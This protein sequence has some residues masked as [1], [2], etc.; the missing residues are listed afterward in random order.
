MRLRLTLGFTRATLAGALSCLALIAAGWGLT[1][2]RIAYERRQAVE[3]AVR[4]NANLAFAFE[5]HTIST[6]KGLERTLAVLAREYQRRSLTA[7]TPYLADEGSKLELVAAAGVVNQAGKIVFSREGFAGASVADRDYFA[8]HRSSADRSLRIGKPVKARFT[9]RSVIPVTRR[10][11]LPDGGFGGVAFVAIDPEYFTSFYNHVDLGAGGMVVLLGLDGTVR[12][13]REGLS[14]SAGQDMSRSSLYQQLAT[15]DSGSFLTGGRTDGIQRYMSYRTVRGYPLAVAV[16]TTEEHV[17]AE[18]RT[19]ERNYLAGASLGTVVILL[20]TAGLLRLQRRNAL[21]AEEASR[22]QARYRATFDQSAVGIAHATAE[23]RFLKVNRRLCE[24]LG[25]SEEELLARS[26]QDVTHPEDAHR[27]LALIGESIADP[28][29]PIPTIEKRY[30]RSDGTLLWG[31]AS[32]AAVRDPQGR[33]DYFVTMLEDISPRKQ[34]EEALLESQAQF[35]QLANHIPQAFW[36]MDPRARRMRY[37]SPAMEAISGKKRGP[38]ESAWAAWKAMIH[39]EDR[40]RAL[41]AYRSMPDGRLDVE[42][43]IVGTDGAVRWVHVRGFPVPGSA[44]E[45]YRVAGT[46]EDVTQHKRA[47]DE[48]RESERRFGAMLGNVELISMMLDHGARITYCNDYL[49]R[50]TGWQRDEVLGRNWFELFIPPE[51]LEVK[52]VFSQLLAESP[53][54]LHHENEILTRSGERRMIRWNNS[55]L[56]SAAG[57]VIGTASIGEDITEQQREHADLIKAEARYR[58]TFDE[59][60]IGITHTSLDGRLIRVNRKFCEMLGYGETELVGA[61]VDRV[62]HPED[63][64]L[65]AAQRTRMLYAGAAPAVENRNVRKDG[66]VLWVHVST[67]LVRDAAGAPDYLVAMVQDITE[68]KRAEATLQ[69]QAYH[70]SLTGLPNRTLFYDRIEQ[71]VSYARRREATAAALVLDL[72]R[73]KMVND[74]LGHAVGDRLLQ[75][76]AKRL[77]ACV[78]SGDTVARVGG[79]EFGVLLADMASPQDASIVGEKILDALALPFEVEGHEVFLTASAGIAAFPG[80]GLDG[81]TLIRNADAAMSRAK[82]RGRNNYQ[83]YTAEMNARAM[84]K[85]LLQNDLRRALERN[86]FLLHYQPKAS[87]ASGRIT[88]FEALLRWQHPRRGLVSP[89]QFVP[90]LEDSGLIVPVGEWVLRSACGQIVAWREAGLE[91]L[92]VAVNLSAKQFFHGDVVAVVEAALAGHGVD[93]RLLDLEITESDVMRN[94]EEAAAILRKLR[95]R[96]VRIGID[97]FGTGYS[98]LSYLKRL[99]VECLKIDRSFVS[100]LPADADDASI[101]RAVITM[102][103]SLGLRV[104]A[105]GVENEAQRRFLATHEC[106]EMQGYLLSRPQPALEAAGFLHPARALLDERDGTQAA[107]G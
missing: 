34:A 99:P 67:A 9:P 100:G 6:L 15:G 60:S 28:S 16:G 88:G 94:P 95:D 106:D 59:A 5:E 24:L 32:V 44:G 48:L 36:I 76:I 20:F 27:M 43:R 81:A 10:I 70:D 53:E 66:S 23:G 46:T 73:F 90:L 19:R 39:P 14:L 22:S 96:G 80:D 42:H 50:V 21:A 74:S 52:E 56:R 54:A 93:P 30:L 83:F 3:E 69:H 107:L 75:E 35:N 41:Q 82:E 49:L 105:E 87:L 64:A 13:R 1:L 31:M 91:P 57:E 71:A 86:E 45:L 47:A 38:L 37:L 77:S 4:H 17:L 98:S 79:D 63:R 85:L 89:A 51:S 72:D 68:R 12:A 7:D 2:E 97:D 40:Q 55:V 101:A 18:F 61:P 26:W 92:P 58:A 25:Y 29:A 78:R 33:L 102:A 103:H 11:D 62:I 65:I 84:E 8:Y 104:V